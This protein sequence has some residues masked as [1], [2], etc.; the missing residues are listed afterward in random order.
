MSDELKPCPFCGSQNIDPAEWSGN[1][2]KFGPGCTDCGALAESADDWNRRTAPVSAP[3]GQELPPLPEPAGQMNKRQTKKLE[4][5]FQPGYTA[6]QFRQGQRDAI[7]PYAE[8]IRQIERELAERRPR[9]ALDP[10]LKAALEE[11]AK[12]RSTVALLPDGEPVFINYGD[13]PEDTADLSCTA[14]GG[15]GHIDD[16][17]NIASRAERKT[18]SIDTPEFR[19]IAMAFRQCSWRFDGTEPE[20]AALIAYIDGRT[21]GT[22]KGHDDA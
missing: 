5:P 17:R 9:V 7:A 19:R 3:M 20:Y 14:C 13:Q 12:T 10:E 21:A 1:D 18:A 6:D 15:S 11:A 8:R 16:Q 2:G 22:E 4:W